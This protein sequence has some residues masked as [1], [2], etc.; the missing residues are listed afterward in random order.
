MSAYAAPGVYYERVDSGAAAVSLL[1]TDIAGFVGMAARGPLHIPMPVQSWRQFQ[2]YFG[3]CIGGGY[4]AYA[5][6]AFFENGGRRA[7]VVRIASSWADSAAFDLADQA[8]QPAWS[9]RAISP[10]AWGNTLRVAV[11]ATHRLQT[12]MDPLQS[13]PEYARV[14]SVAGFQRGTHV[15]IPIKPGVAVYRM[16]AAVDAST[17]RLYW[18]DPDPRGRSDAQQPLTGLDPNSTPLL[19][20]VEY[21]VLAFDGVRLLATYEGLS[22]LPDHPRYGPQ[23]LAPLPAPPP[24]PRDWKL[25]DT[26]PT[27]CI[28][29]LRTPARIDAMQPLADAAMGS[30][31]SGGADGLSQLRVRDFIGEPVDLADDD[32]V[33]RDKTRGLAALAAI[34]EVALLAV[35]DIHI[36]PEQPPLHQPLPPCIPDP[37]LPQPPP[38][39]AVRTSVEAD[40]PPRFS[41]AAVYQ[42][43]ASMVQQCET[44]RDRFALL[45]APYDCVRDPRLGVAAVR[46]WR[47]R[48]DSP[49]AALYFPWVRVVDTLFLPTVRSRDIPAS[50]HAA[51][52]CATTD[53]EVGVH[54]AP[55]NGEL[56]W[57]QDL[58][59]PVDTV[60]HGL[61]NDEH[62]DVLRAF[63]GRGLRIFG[64]RTLSSDPDWA[65]INVRRLVSMIGKALKQS[66]QWAVFEPNDIVTRT[67]LHLA[68]T[69]FL[70]ILWQRGAL[71]GKAARSAFYVICNEDNNP[72]AI[73]D[74]GQ[75]IVEV[76]IAPAIPFEFV[77]L[78][79]GRVG[80]EFDITDT[81]QPGGHAS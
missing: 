74:D 1:R 41:D 81:G 70:L 13:A 49:F 26:P 14:A 2:A 80:N 34:S 61:L 40:L 73:R 59:Q 63:P 24:D 31:L 17:H 68:I 53:I 72:P 77:V 62:I 35:P 46:A 32:A 4:L 25:P 37:C 58:T 66:C 48:F 54:K 57:L 55:A 20:S 21:T 67:K 39:D 28:V 23:V 45:D 30:M 36:Q 50:G 11:R 18:V 7:W 69:S 78:R 3:D 47:Q 15:R 65:Y 79:V 27:L 52:F 38:P 56:I 75:L 60:T 64:A 10:G 29:E 19:E 33:R 44:L 71:A 51:G 76:G 6:R 9:I 43:Q 12:L 8:A 5:V 16:V 22:L 42:V